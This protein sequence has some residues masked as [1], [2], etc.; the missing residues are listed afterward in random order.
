M[1]DLGVSFI[2]KMFLPL[3]VCTLKSCPE[4]CPFCSCKRTKAFFSSLLQETITALIHLPGLKCWLVPV[5]SGWHIFH[6]RCQMNIQ[7]G[8]GG[9]EGTRLHTEPTDVEEL[10]SSL[11]CPLISLW[12]ACWQRWGSESCHG[13]R[14]RGGWCPKGYYAM[15]VPGQD[16]LPPSPVQPLSACPML[17]ATTKRALGGCHAS[18]SITIREQS[19]QRLPTVSA[20]CNALI[21]AMLN[22]IPWRWIAIWIPSFLHLKPHTLTWIGFD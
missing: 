15:A 5:C 1:P 17:R 9:W 10:L 20:T 18:S 19:V 3:K 6:Q 21:K 12:D 13:L 22:H 7:S 16:P 14:V 2:H 8:Y 11:S 4:L